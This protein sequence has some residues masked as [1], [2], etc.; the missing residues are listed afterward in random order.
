MPLDL[1]FYLPFRHFKSPNT[2]CGPLINDHTWSFD[3]ILVFPQCDL[4][5][6][7]LMPGG[8]IQMCL[9]LSEEICIYTQGRSRWQLSMVGMNSCLR[10]RQSRMY[11]LSVVGVLSVWQ[12]TGVCLPLS[13]AERSQGT[14][15]KLVLAGCRQ[16]RQG[17]RLQTKQ[18]RKGCK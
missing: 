2:F 10:L 17:I 14:L 3:E 13:E 11:L 9:F 6:F 7:V 16:Q 8:Y 18:C 4:L 5:T 1:I 12:D 15:K